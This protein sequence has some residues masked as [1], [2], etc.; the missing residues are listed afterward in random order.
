MKRMSKSEAHKKIG[1][2]RAKILKV[3]GAENNRYISVREF[4]N[5]SE[6]LIKIQNKIKKM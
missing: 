4:M 3:Y 2:C 1:E 6:A 5:L